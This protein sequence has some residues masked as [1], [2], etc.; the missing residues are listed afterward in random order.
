MPYKEPRIFPCLHSFCQQCLNQEIERSG[1]KQNM[2][3]PT[4][5][6]SITIPEGGVNAIPENLHLGFEVEVA[7]YMSK[8]G[9]D[10][11][12]PCDACID[13]STGPAVVFCCTCH[14][15]LCAYCY[16]SHK[17]NRKMSDHSIV[18]LDMNSLK[19][20]PSLMKPTDHL[21][22]QRD[23]E[24]KVLK[25]YCKTCQLLTCRDCTLFCHKDHIVA[26]MC[27]MAKVHR[28][29]MKEALGCAQEVVSK[30]P[31][32]IDANYKNIQQIAKLTTETQ[33]V[34]NRSF[35]KRDHINEEKRKRLLSE[36]E[37]ISLHKTTALTLQRKNLMKMQEEVG[38]Y[39]EMT[40]NILQTHTDQELV[41]LGHLVPTELKA[42]LKRVPISQNQSRDT[43]IYVPLNTNILNTALCRF[44]H[45]MGLSLSPSQST[46]SSESVAKVKEMY[47]LKV[48]TMSTEG[49]RYPFGGLQ[50]KAELKPKLHG[51][52]IIR[53]EVNDHGDGTYTITLTPQ[54]GGPHMLLI[55][56]DGQNVQKSPFDLDVI[57][58]YSTLGNPGQVINCSNGP[59]GIA[60]HDSGDIYAVCC[61]Q[62]RICVFD[63]SG[64]QKRIIGS[65]GSGDGQFRGP[66]GIFIKRDVMYVADVG[67][68]RI[69][70]LTIEGEVIQKYGQ[71]GSG[72]GQFNGP[73]AVIVD[74]RDRLIVADHLN[75][76][77][78]L[79][80]QAGTWLLTIKGNVSGPQNFENPYGLALDSQGNIHVAA[81]GS[82]TIKVFS[83]EGT[84]VRSY[85]SVHHPSGIVVDEEGY[86]LVIEETDNCLSIFDPQGNKIHMVHK[87]SN[88]Q[89]VILD[90][91]SGSLYIANIRA[92]TVFKYAV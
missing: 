47:C 58:K 19:L 65:S 36:I 4:C 53:G 59:S 7:G 57:T 42:I 34:I 63:K 28:D 79:L 48:E 54:T 12:K 11:E 76:R 17:R 9:S 83:P 89:G 24:A 18:G 45:E 5:Q 37:A 10:G 3:C 32:A 41:A 2:E 43:Y 52:A 6:R 70:K 80:D 21:C 78:V 92:K 29:D 22:S 69:Q 73:I 74:Q 46:W 26:E 1:T 75:H 64:K 88:P 13:G 25:F 82:S 14:E 40:S 35:E 60:I 30:L 33:L 15:L 20:L 81:R 31:K 61:T 55:T 66:H 39:T 8:I 84:Y 50:V 62:S 87:L 51:G 85:G 71:R 44:S 68:D 86:S 27:N 38:R 49:Q 72:Q 90:Q 16:E 56:M 91:K 23:H 67:N 77:V